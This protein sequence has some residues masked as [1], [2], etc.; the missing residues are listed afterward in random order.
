M[1][2]RFSIRYT[3]NASIEDISA[4]VLPNE[5]GIEKFSGQL[6]EPVSRSGS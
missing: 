6:D 4:N 1:D 5:E 2:K 3:D